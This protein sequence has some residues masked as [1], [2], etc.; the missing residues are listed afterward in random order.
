M[1][2]Y[3]TKVRT[4]RPADEVFPY[5]ADLRNFA[6]W[7]PGVRRVAQ[8]EGDGAG[9]DAVFDVTVAGVGRDLTL[10]YRT[11]EYAPP[12]SLL[13]LAESTL[14]T[15]EDRITVEAEDGGCVVTYDADLRLN[16]VLR[17]ADPGLRLVFG[18]IGDRAAAGLRQ[19]LDGQPV[20]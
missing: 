16:G 2:R 19:A 1:A 17:L 7:D 15:S 4:D 11:V 9:P 8:V 3:I 20:R 10:R 13:V 12:R 18:R 6:E 14:F 5:L